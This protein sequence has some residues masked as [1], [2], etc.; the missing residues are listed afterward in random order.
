MVLVPSHGHLA[1]KYF[2]NQGCQ[3]THF[4]MH[5]CTCFTALLLGLPVWTSTRKVK[6]I[7]ILLKQETVSGSGISWAICMSA[8]CSR[9]ITMPATHHSVFHSPDALPAAQPAAS[10][11]WRHHRDMHKKVKVAHTRLL[12]VGFWSWSQFLAVSLQVTWVINPAVGCHYFPPVPQLLSQPL[13]G[14][15]SVLLLGEQRHDGCKQFA[16]ECYPTASRLQ[17]EPRPFCAWFQHANHSATKLPYKINIL[18]IIWLFVFLVIF[19]SVQEFAL[20]WLSV[21]KQYMFCVV[22][23]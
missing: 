3:L 13:R 20:W 19:C 7:W 17:F 2:L 8:H 10:K 11:H 18:A 9:Q 22:D 4:D 12:I 15:L 16:Y 14:L 5:T 21:F 1:N 6:P 23:G